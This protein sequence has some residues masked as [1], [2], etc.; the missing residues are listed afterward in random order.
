MA[1]TPWR[2]AADNNSEEGIVST[3]TTD[4]A[5]TNLAVIEEIYAAFG[6]GDVAP[7][8]DAFFSWSPTNRV[9]AV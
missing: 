7:I 5:A 4:R 6:R 8:L 2:M 3:R 9:R 1:A